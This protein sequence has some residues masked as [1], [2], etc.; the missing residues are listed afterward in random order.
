MHTFK[1][2]GYDAAWDQL[3]EWHKSLRGKKRAAAGRLLQHVAER[4]GSAA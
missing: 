3:T 2:E 1:H 4:H